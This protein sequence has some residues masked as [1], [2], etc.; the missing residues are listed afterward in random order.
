MQKTEIAAG[1]SEG[2]D[3]EGSIQLCNLGDFSFC[4]TSPALHWMELLQQNTAEE[5]FGF[6]VLGGECSPR[7]NR[8]TG[9]CLRKT[10]GCRPIEVHASWN[11]YLPVDPTHA[12]QGPTKK[13]PGEQN[14][15]K[16]RK[17]L[18]PAKTMTYLSL[19]ELLSCLLTSNL[20][21]SLAPKK[22]LLALT[23]RGPPFS[24]G[25]LP[26]PFF[27]ARQNHHPFRRRVAAKPGS[28]VGEASPQS[29]LNGSSD[30][31]MVKNVNG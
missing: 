3:T 30:P 29:P 7:I 9:G 26:E 16:Q 5:V 8:F 10:K 4:V 6:Y 2:V 1:E 17:T 27:G 21:N 22:S 24:K 31:S 12:L 28:C 25:S 13:K 18:L 23:P 11:A 15:F 20:S 19:S 14:P